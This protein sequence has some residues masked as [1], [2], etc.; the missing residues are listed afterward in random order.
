MHIGLVWLFSLCCWKIV[1]TESTLFEWFLFQIYVII[2][3]LICI[4]IYCVCTYLLAFT[5]VF[6]FFYVYFLKI[7]EENSFY[8]V[9]FDL[10][11]D[12]FFGSNIVIHNFIVIRFSENLLD[13]I[14]QIKHFFKKIFF[15]YFGRK[16]DCMFDSGRLFSDF[17]VPIF[18]TLALIGCNAYITLEVRR[19]LAFW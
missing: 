4:L 6:Y 12:S 16:G 1:L 11:C 14:L 5:D 7:R 10:I 19:L 3:C 15:Y 18:S 17:R 9:H 2:C 8:K 13:V